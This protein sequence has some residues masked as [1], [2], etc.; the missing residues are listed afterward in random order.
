MGN[1]KKL[2]KII[3]QCL[4]NDWLDKDPFKFYKITTK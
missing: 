2:K 1:I 4:A 3:R